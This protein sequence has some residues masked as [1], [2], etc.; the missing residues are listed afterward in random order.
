AKKTRK[1]VREFVDEYILANGHSVMVL[2]EGRLIN[3][4]AA[5]GHPASVMDMSFAVQALATEWALKNRKTLDVKVHNV[6]AAID[7]WVAA[8]KL[9]AMGISI[10]TLTK[11]QLKYLSSHDMGT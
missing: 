10:D 9:E 4:A 1:G 5:H 8:L 11:E 6:P 7:E 3:L 2:G